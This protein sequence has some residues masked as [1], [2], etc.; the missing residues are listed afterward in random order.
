MIETYTAIHFLI[1]VLIQG[2]FQSQHTVLAFSF[3]NTVYIF[4]R[5]VLELFGNHNW[6]RSINGSNH[7]KYYQLIGFST[8]LLLS[9]FIPDAAI[10]HFSNFV[11]VIGVFYKLIDNVLFLNVSFNLSRTLR[12]NIDEQFNFSA[13][14]LLF[15]AIV[16][17]VVGTFFK[18]KVYYMGE[19]A[20]FGISILLVIGTVLEMVVILSTILRG[21]NDCIITNWA[22]F[23]LYSNYRLYV[24]SI[25]NK[26]E[27]QYS[28]FEISTLL[29][30]YF[31]RKYVR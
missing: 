19:D 31:R 18:V 14:L 12:Q 25:G 7:A 6:N 8:S 1:S 22:F 11:I 24:Y 9:R 16:E 26:L 13:A 5:I 17:L 15:I 20:N 27:N 2:L 21:Q 30:E 29:S 10:S 23:Y 3:C 28:N 4:S